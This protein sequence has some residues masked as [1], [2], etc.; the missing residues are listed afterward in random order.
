VKLVSPEDEEE[1][2]LSEVLKTQEGRRIRSPMAVSEKRRQEKEQQEPG[3]ESS[4]AEAGMQPRVGQE[5][6]QAGKRDQDAAKGRGDPSGDQHLEIALERK[7]VVRARLQDKEG[8]GVGMPQGKQRKEVGKVQQ[9]TSPE[10]GGCRL[11][12]VKILTRQGR[13]SM[14][15]KTASEVTSSLNQQVSR[16]GQGTNSW[17][18][19]SWVLGG[20][21]RE[22]KPESAR[23]E[24]GPVGFWGRLF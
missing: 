23:R 15:E 12:E 3:V 1:H 20:R 4:R 19:R 14:E 22:G 6:I 11:R 2:K 5:S 16:N 7:V 21:Q 13:R 18:A 9:Q 8:Q 10:L 24:M 17:G